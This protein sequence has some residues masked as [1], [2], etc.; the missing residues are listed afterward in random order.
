MLQYAQDEGMSR[1][2]GIAL[3]AMTKQVHGAVVVK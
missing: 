2:R 3:G 1:Y